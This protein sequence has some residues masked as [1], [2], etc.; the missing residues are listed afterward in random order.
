MVGCKAFRQEK[1]KLQAPMPQCHGVSVPS[2]VLE[3]ETNLANPEQMTCPTKIG[4]KKGV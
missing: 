1:R 2:H 3:F 4:S